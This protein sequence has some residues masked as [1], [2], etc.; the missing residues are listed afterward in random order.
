MANTLEIRICPM[1]EKE[2][3]GHSAISRTPGKEEICTE[4][5]VKQALNCLKIATSKVCAT[6]MINDWS[7]SDSSGKTFQFIT[8]CL[9]RHIHLDYGNID[10]KSRKDNDKAL[11]NGGMI[12]SAY[13]IP[14][15]MASNAKDSRLWIITSENRKTTTIMFPIEY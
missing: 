14:W 10:R 8:D 2:Y 6:N 12:F 4:C 5:G 7:A 13:D 15:E 11:T 1:C 9:Q 3:T